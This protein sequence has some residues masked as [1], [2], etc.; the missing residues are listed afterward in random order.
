M[1]N[2]D[3]IRRAR[4]TLKEGLSL[5]DLVTKLVNLIDETEQAENTLFEAIYDLYFMYYPEAA[6]LLKERDKFIEIVSNGVERGEVG[7]YLKIST[8]SMGY[9]LSADDRSLLNLHVN[10]I[11]N[12][13]DMRNFT[14]TYLDKTI[15]DAYPNIY[16]IADYMVAARLIMLSGGI[17]SLAFMPSSKIQILGSE[18]ALFSHFKKGK[19]SPKYG[20]I[21]KNP[22]IEG[23]PQE[24][25]GKIA[26][27][28]AAQISTA[29]KL[30]F[31]SKKDDSAVL[32]EKLE[33]EIDRI[34]KNGTKKSNR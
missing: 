31:F 5:G 19:S 2:I 21:F 10:E 13:S 23:A 20:V 14:K 22:A 27:A 34:M 1:D 11:K 15:H 16:G 28:L 6:V 29:A 9:D 12:L 25:R 3:Y 17:K 18:K 7:N 8:E 24:K 26:R 4:K 30:D 32:R 33:K